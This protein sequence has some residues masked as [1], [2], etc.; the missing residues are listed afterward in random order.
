MD[1]TPLVN[2]LVDFSCPGKGAAKKK[3]EAYEKKTDLT[4][5]HGFV[6]PLPRLGDKAFNGV[7]NTY[8]IKN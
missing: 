7:L 4:H 3:G 8:F 2:P 6:P 5:S 1:H